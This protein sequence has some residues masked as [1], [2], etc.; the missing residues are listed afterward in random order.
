MTREEAEKLKT[1]DH[2][3]TCGGYASN[4]NGRNS[5]QPHMEWCPQLPQWMEWKAALQEQGDE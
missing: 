4:M 5:E 1:F 2:Y 3:C